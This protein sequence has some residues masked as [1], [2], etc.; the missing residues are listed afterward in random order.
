M[1]NKLFVFVSGILIGMA[2][3]TS[4]VFALGTEKEITVNY[5]PLKFFFSGV[6]KVPPAGE[7][8]FVY[9]GRTYVPLR[10]MAESMG[11]PVKWQAE[12][13]SIYVGAQPQDFVRLND[14]QVLSN[15]NF[16]SHNDFYIAGK[17]YSYGMLLGQEGSGHLN[18]GESGIID[19]NLR[20]SYITLQ[21][22][23][24]ISDVNVKDNNSKA[25]M[26][27]MGDGKELYRSQLKGPGD[28]PE[29]FSLSVR[30]VQRLSIKIGSTGPA[31]YALVVEPKLIPKP[32][33]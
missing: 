23:F 11:Q 15:I 14:I 33:E 18:P 29:E 13:S 24:G 30:G 10:F 3:F 9:N 21:G 28:Q 27:V 19:Y 6:E 4:V 5:L 16:I 25:L 22:S 26:I 2:I 20:D 7:E 12:T 17:K 31:I 32:V 1:K 8:G